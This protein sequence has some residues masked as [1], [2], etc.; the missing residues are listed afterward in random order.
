[1]EIFWVQWKS[2]QMS[3]EK[4]YFVQKVMIEQTSRTKMGKNGIMWLK[5]TEGIRKCTINRHHRID[6]IPPLNPPNEKLS[7]FDLFG[8]VPKTSQK[9][10]VSS[11]AAETTQAPSGL[12][13]M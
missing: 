4:E 12:C 6:V 8:G 11:A 3:V 9:R 13:S 7:V 5:S 2:I 10:R 1:M